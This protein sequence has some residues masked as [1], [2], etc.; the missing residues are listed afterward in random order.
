MLPYVAPAVAEAQ[1]ITYLDR[2]SVGAVVFASTGPST[3][4][5]YWYLIDTLGQPQVVR[6]GFAI[7]LPTDGHWPAR[8]VG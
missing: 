1:L 5:G 4:I 3:S 6:P 2:Y 8:P 7:W